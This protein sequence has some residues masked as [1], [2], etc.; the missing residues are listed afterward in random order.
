M[1]LR[2]EDLHVR[3]TANAMVTQNLH[4]DDF[5][6]LGNTV[7]LRNGS[8]STVGPVAMY[9]LVLVSPKGLPP[10]GTSS[11]GGVFDV[12]TSVCLVQ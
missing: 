5:R 1:T 8:S 4:S 12:D 3:G 9:V 11:E 7:W 2:E 10:R 6:G